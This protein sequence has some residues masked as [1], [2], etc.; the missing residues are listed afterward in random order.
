MFYGII[1]EELFY[2]E[3]YCDFINENSKNVINEQNIDIIKENLN[4]DTGSGAK[5]HP[6]Y[7]LLIHGETAFDHVAQVLVRKK[8]T[9]WHAALSFGP[10]LSTCYSFR[11]GMSSTTVNPHFSGG[12]ALESLDF[13][14]SCSPKG[15]MQVGVVF[16]NNSKFRKIKEA[17]NYFLNNKEKT[18]YNFLNLLFSLVGIPTANG[19]KLNQ[20]CTTFVDTVLKYAH[21]NISD[22]QINLTKADDMKHTDN[23]KGYFKV[24]EGEIVDYKEDLVIKKSEKLANTLKNDY[25]KH[26]KDVEAEDITVK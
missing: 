25:F 11:G 23:R 19:L 5:L 13:Y 3:D 24:F 21:I 8:Q 12:L 2:I 9:Y 18:R 4:K 14:K 26:N 7:I 22:K 6:I 15:R 10:S 17:L 1:R 20:I 16:V